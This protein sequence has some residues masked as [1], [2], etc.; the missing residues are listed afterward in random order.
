MQEI[1]QMRGGRTLFDTAFNFVHFHVYRQ[2][3]QPG[4]LDVL[5]YDF[6]EETNFPFLAQFTSHPDGT[7]IELLLVYDATQ[8]PEAH[9]Q[10]IAGCYRQ[11]L[12]ASVAQPDAAPRGIR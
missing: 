12:E 10:R 8:F 4:G 3:L 2:L 1:R 5:G 7:Q 9:V 6:R 11:I